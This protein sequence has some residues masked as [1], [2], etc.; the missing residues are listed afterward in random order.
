[1]QGNEGLPTIGTPIQFA[2]KRQPS[3]CVLVYVRVHLKAED[4]LYNLIPLREMRR[5]F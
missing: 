2:L 3:L 4:S 1:M 5:Y